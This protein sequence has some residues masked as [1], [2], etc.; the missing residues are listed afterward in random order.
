ML[1]RG[2]HYK[3]DSR[4]DRA[5]PSSRHGADL[6]RSIESHILSQLRTSFIVREIC[7]SSCMPP[8]VNRH[9]QFSEHALSGNITEYRVDCSSFDARGSPLRPSFIWD[10]VIIGVIS[11]AFVVRANETRLL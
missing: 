7:L 4:E 1:T 2:L 3:T 5:R 6:E 10:A 8:L 11:W 9:P